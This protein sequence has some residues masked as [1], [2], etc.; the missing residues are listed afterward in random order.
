MNLLNRRKRTG[1]V[2]LTAD[3]LIYIFAALVVLATVY[4]MYYVFI[5]SISA[6]REAVTMRVSW[7]PKGFYLDGYSKVIK[8]MRL[9]R[10][11][12]NTIIYAVTTAFGM[13][14]TC[15][16]AGYPLSS[17]KLFGRKFLNIYLLIPMYITGGLIPTF[18]LITKLGLYNTPL[19]IIIPGAINIWYIILMK[20][21]FDSI[22]ESMRESARIDGAN[23]YTILLKIYIPLSKPILAVIA[24]YTIINVWNNWFNA[25]LYIVNEKWQ[26]LQI[27]LRKILVKG[28]IDLTKE[29]LSP[30]EIIVA[31]Q[32]KLS[33]EQLKYTVVILSSIPMLLAYPFFQKYFVKGV[34][35]GSLKE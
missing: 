21:F 1:T 15:V 17:K 3:I 8:D 18:L 16:L 33:N 35:I 14:I 20:S 29:I 25:A 30:E 24:L 4:P 9:W 28:E 2:S 27:Y 23:N 10:S 13:L 31:M 22:P 12:L 7:F 5:L 11:Y 34:M 19:A 26:P 6:P 32:Q